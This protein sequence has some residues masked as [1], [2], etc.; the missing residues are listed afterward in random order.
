M[1]IH[2]NNLIKSLFR[3]ICNQKLWQSLN[4][5]KSISSSPTPSPLVPAKCV[6][7]V[8]K[9]IF[10]FP[11]NFHRFSL[12]RGQCSKYFSSFHARYD[13]K[14]KFLLICL[15]RWND[16]WFLSPQFEKFSKLSESEIFHLISFRSRFIWN[17][18]ERD[19][20]RFN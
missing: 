15:S 10:Y 4:D 2:F 8:A 12:P 6:C 11:Q 13:K 20:V 18:S 16:W 3:A 9:W 5:I 14:L 17:H 1:K 19:T 7:Y